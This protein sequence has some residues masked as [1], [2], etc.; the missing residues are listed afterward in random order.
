MSS[1]PEQPTSIRRKLAPTAAAFALSVGLAG[2]ESSTPTSASAESQLVQETLKQ[3]TDRQLKLVHN[4]ISSMLADKDKSVF[5][6]YTEKVTVEGKK[7]TLRVI[8]FGDTIP[9]TKEKTYSY[10]VEYLN[11]PGEKLPSSLAI[12]LGG[13]TPRFKPGADFE[14]ETVLLRNPNDTDNYLLAHF[15]IDRQSGK[16]NQSY[17]ESNPPNNVSWQNDGSRKPI[18]RIRMG[19]IFEDFTGGAAS[20]LG[21]IKGLENQASGPKA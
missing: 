7:Q 14:N 4:R 6:G 5:T 17:Y 8:S 13:S 21:H 19:E 2:Y 1:K 20:L 3:R 10:V 12:I 15:F 18:S 16:F 11:K 9:G